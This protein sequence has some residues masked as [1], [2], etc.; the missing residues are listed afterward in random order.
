MVLVTYANACPPPCLCDSE[1]G[2][3]DCSE[4]TIT[5]LPVPK[6][7]WSGPSPVMHRGTSSDL[8]HPGK[9]SAVATRCSVSS[10]SATTLIYPAST[11][12]QS[13]QPWKYFRTASSFCGLKYVQ[14][15]S[16][17]L[18]TT[19]G[20]VFASEKWAALYMESTVVIPRITVALN[21]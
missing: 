9:T 3:L 20:T 19:R 21:L 1:E 8:F 7:L 11:P 18:T 13:S 4:L 15:N 5:E 16:S 6:L 2:I 17:P 10:I 14:L 12:L